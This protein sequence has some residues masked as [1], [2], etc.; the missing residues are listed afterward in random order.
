MLMSKDFTLKGGCEAIVLSTIK[1]NLPIEVEDLVK[2]CSFIKSSGVFM[3][4]SLGT[5]NAF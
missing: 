5:T 3:T 1:G 4:N 2:P